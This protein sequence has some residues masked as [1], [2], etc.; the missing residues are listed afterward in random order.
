MWW[1]ILLIIGGFPILAVV[2]QVISA[3][4]RGGC[5]LLT[6]TGIVI[7]ALIGSMSGFPHH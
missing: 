3:L 2:G 7:F 4:L 1:L 5:I 6:I